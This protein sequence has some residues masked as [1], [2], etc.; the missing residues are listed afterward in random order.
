VTPL[1]FKLALDDERE[2]V[3]S[4][5]AIRTGRLQHICFEVL[6]VGL[7]PSILNPNV[8]PWAPFGV[9]IAAFHVP[10]TSVADAVRIQLTKS[11]FM[12]ETHFARRRLAATV[13]RSVNADA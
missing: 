8:V 13:T 3:A 4:T 7:L 9:S 2:V 1:P 10:E 5:V 12:T 11:E 6:P